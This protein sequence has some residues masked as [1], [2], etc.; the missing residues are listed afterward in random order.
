MMKSDKKSAPAE[1]PRVTDEALDAIEAALE[2]LHATITGAMDGIDRR[3]DRR[4]KGLNVMRIHAG[5]ALPNKLAE[6]RKLQA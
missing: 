4:I 2:A 3:D 1:R 5:E 6:I